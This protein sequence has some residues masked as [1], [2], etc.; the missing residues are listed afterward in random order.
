MG[1][2]ECSAG[3]TIGV[4]ELVAAVNSKVEVIE[5]A[6]TKTVASES[7]AVPG[8]FDFQN[9]HEAMQWA[10][11]PSSSSL[12]VFEL[13][14]GDHYI[15]Q[16]D[17]NYGNQYVINNNITIRGSDREVCFVTYAPT[18]A[19]TLANYTFSM[20]NNI[21][22]FQNVTFDPDK[23]GL[24]R[25]NYS[26]LGFFD[27]MDITYYLV[28][29]K[30]MYD[31]GTF[32]TNVDVM[33]HELKI[34]NL[35]QRGLYINGNINVRVY[36]GEATDCPEF[37]HIVN[38]IGG[39]LVRVSVV[40]VLTN[41]PFCNED[42]DTVLA[43]GTIVYSTTAQWSGTTANR[44]VFIDKTTSSNIPYFDTDLGK[45]IW[46]NGTAWVDSAGTGV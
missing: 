15:Y 3:T 16:T 4:T 44:P 33:L 22:R 29:I 37:I 5:G 40:P 43:G 21:V 27:N 19:D 36:G 32:Y 38:G 45:P 35:S 13:D 14:D 24:T 23:G 10:E 34:E 8:D 25:T 7:S 18:S 30:N 28:S 17:E 41:T 42:T 1:T 26:I 31:A 12:L 2:L 9:F 39:S 11:I 6:V 20:N 46:Y